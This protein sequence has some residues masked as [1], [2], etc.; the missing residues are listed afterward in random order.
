[1]EEKKNNQP[2]VNVNVPNFEQILKNPNLVRNYV[3]GFIVGNTQT[4]ILIVSL[5]NGTPQIVTNM[6]FATAKNLI[7][8]LSK[9]ISDIE[10]QIGEVKIVPPTSF[11][12]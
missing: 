1:M 12:D 4:D 6:S 8:T 7:T 3:N 9:S 11:A 5:V 2:A 10:K